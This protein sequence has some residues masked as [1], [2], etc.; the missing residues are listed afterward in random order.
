MGSCTSSP[1]M[2]KQS[3]SVMNLPVTKVAMVIQ[4]N[5]KLQEFRQPITAGEILVQ[6][7]DFFLC[8]SEAMNVNSLVPQLAK[9]EI[10]QLGQLYFLLPVSKLQT[11]FSLQDICVLAV[12]ASTALNDYFN[13]STIVDGSSRILTRRFKKMHDC[14]AKDL[15]LRSKVFESSLPLQ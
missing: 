1:L 5:G 10:L 6:N 12:K 7:P 14:H 15:N 2:T 8:S 4:M 9:D 13:L 3:G 11:P